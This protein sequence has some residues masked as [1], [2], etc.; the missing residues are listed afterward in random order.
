MIDNT[1]KTSLSSCVYDKIM[2]VIKFITD[3][4]EPAEPYKTD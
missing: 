4:K 3:W 1:C 2:V